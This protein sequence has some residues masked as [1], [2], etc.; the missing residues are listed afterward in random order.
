MQ[1]VYGFVVNDLGLSSK[2]GYAVLVLLV[3]L[4]FYELYDIYK[5]RNTGAVAL[6]WLLVV[7]LLP[8]GTLVYLGIGRAHIRQAPAQ[9]PQPLPPAAVPT[10]NPQANLY[11]Q[12]QG[13]SVST[14]RKAATT[15]GSIVGAIALAA[16]AIAVV[17]FIF[18]GIA[19]IQCA[20][21]PKC[22]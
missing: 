4:F 3:L 18:I 16:G 9:K 17:F 11:K 22:M 13:T 8:L 10:Q 7:L 2:I 15:I 14:G 21:D 5:H 20:N 19:M 12:E 6:I 1:W